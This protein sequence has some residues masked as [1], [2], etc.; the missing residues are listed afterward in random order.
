[1]SYDSRSLEAK[2]SSVLCAPIKVSIS[3][4]SHGK[5][6]VARPD[7][8]PSRHGFSFL[9]RPVYMDMVSSELMF[10]SYGHNVV[11]EWEANA[12]TTAGVAW[13]Y[14]S[15]L[16]YK[17]TIQ[18][19][20]SGR[21]I[22][23]AS[24]L[25]NAPSDS[26]RAQNIRMKLKAY[27]SDCIDTEEAALQSSLGFAL[28]LAGYPGM[29]NSVSQAD[30][31]VVEGR[32]HL[33]ESMSYERSWANR[34][35]CLAY[36]G[37]RCAVCDFDFGEM[38]GQEYAGIIE[39]HHIRPL[40]SLSEPKPV[41]PVTDLVPLC[42]NCHTAIHSTNPPLTPEELREIYQKRKNLR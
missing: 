21:R 40:S 3:Y 12:R 22:T 18:L 10:D 33:T 42:P 26:W 29:N 39:V 30:H 2:L 28:L 20:I 41:N 37:T 32:T 36:H 15:N 35:R 31:D 13:D 4:D 11:D 6:V 27:K 34:M 7:I 5:K 17:T 24:E 8:Y 38:Y 16:P 1:M 23:N 19:T 9:C 25:S 14:L